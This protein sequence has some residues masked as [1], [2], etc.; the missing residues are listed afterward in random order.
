MRRSVLS[1]AFVLTLATISFAQTTNSS[2]NSVRPRTTTNTNT[3]QKPKVASSPKPKATSETP[4]PVK[5]RPAETPG[6]EAVLASFNKIL[7]GIR[8]ANVD[9]VTNAYW[10]SRQLILFNS[11]GSVTR[12]WDQL[13]KNRESSY[14]DMKDVQLD[15]HDVHVLM[16]G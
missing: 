14:P 11:N 3:A 16:L 12:G 10:N 7:N 13:R 6:S 15:A 5:K 9:E 8:H 4:T 2:T 1:I